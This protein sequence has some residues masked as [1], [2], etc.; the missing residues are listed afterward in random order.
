MTRARYVTGLALVALTWTVQAQQSTPAAPAAPAR[1]AL[2]PPPVAKTGNPTPG[3]AQPD[4]PNIA[5]RITVSGCLKLAPGAGAAPASATT[6]PASN[7]YVLTDAKK[8]G[9][10]PPDTGTSTAA[11]AAAAAT[12]RLEALE[13][14]LSPLVNARIELSGEL[15]SPAEAPPVLLV[16]FA[17]KVAAKCQ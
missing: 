4:P 9:R 2:P 17:R 7:R 8:D 16:E 15:K 11:A 14:Q 3:T 6:V 12:Y 5:D 1:P 13:S 10:V